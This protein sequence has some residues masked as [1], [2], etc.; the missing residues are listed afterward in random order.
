LA[1]HV[2]G[3]ADLNLY[4]YVHGS[5]LKSI[6]PVGLA[7]RHITDGRIAFDAATKTHEAFVNEAHA[8]EEKLNAQYLAGLEGQRQ[9]VNCVSGECWQKVMAAQGLARDAESKLYDLRS[10]MEQEASAYEG[11]KASWKQVQEDYQVV[12]FEHWAGSGVSANAIYQGPAKHAVQGSKDSYDK[13]VENI[14]DSGIFG[15]F[16]S[17]KAFVRA[18]SG[19]S[20]HHRQL[21]DDYRTAA[22]TNKIVE[23][24]AEGRGDKLRAHEGAGRA[25]E[26]EATGPERTA[27]SPRGPAPAPPPHTARS[28]NGNDLDKQWNAQRTWVNEFIDWF[29]QK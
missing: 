26:S 19:N 20:V 9:S 11:V 14:R 1:V 10:K 7:D 5:V 6:D 25:F 28:G 17:G 23:A 21:A 22:A 16:V 15:A 8:T 4:A 24:R 3:S 2:P 12:L 27:A 13:V 29:H 18:A